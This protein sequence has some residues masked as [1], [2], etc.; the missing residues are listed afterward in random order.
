M[1]ALEVISRLRELGV[2]ISVDADELVVDAPQGAI[3][4]ELAAQI[5][6]RKVQLIAMLK[7]SARSQRFSDLPLVAAGREQELPLSYAQ[8][9]LWFLDQLEPGSS[10]YNISWTVRLKGELDVPALQHALNAVV[11]R[12]EVL[13]SCFPTIAGQAKLQLRDDVLVP[14]EQSDLN[15]ATDERL[16]AHLSR[17]AA[18][19]FELAKAPLLRVFLVRRTAT[20][21][22]LLVLIHHV[23]S[24]GASMRILFREL[25]QLYDAAVAGNLAAGLSSL[26]PLTIQYPDFALWQREWLSGEQLQQQLD[27]W[28]TKLADAPPVLAL[29]TD[30]P[31]SAALRFRGASV[32]RLLPKELAEDLRALGRTNGATLFMVMFAVFDIVLQR[33]SAQN[34]LVVG[35]PISG[36]SRTSLEG[37]IGF[38]VNT[39]VLRTQLSD[40]M[41]FRDLLRQVR[42][43]ALEAHTHQELPFEKLV[44]VLQPE[45][46]LS[47][48]PIFQVMFDLQE[49]PRWQLPVQNIE[50]IPEVIFSSR[51]STFDL[52]LSVREASNGLDAMFEYDTDLFDESTIEQFAKH[53]EALLHSALAAPDLAISSLP[54]LSES[55]RQHLLFSWG[56]ASVAG[57]AAPSGLTLHGQFAQVLARS[58]DAIAL[59]DA[60]GSEYSYAE[61]NRMADSIAM[62][63]RAQGVEPGSVVGLCA[64]RSAATIAAILGVLKSGAAWLPLDPEYPVERLCVM[65][66]VAAPDVVLVQPEFA[67][68][69]PVDQKQLL[70]DADLIS[71]TN[72]FSG[73]DVRTDAAAC[74]L[75]T[76]GSTG[77]PKGVVLGHGGLA[78]YVSQ[79]ASE[80]KV[81]PAD[82]VLQFA[83]LN[84]DISL[85]EIFVALTSGATLV[86]R[87]AGP[88]PSIQEFLSFCKLH[89]I[90]WLSLPTAY[91][92]EWAAQV[93]QD[94]LLPAE[95]KT[96]IIGGEKAQLENWR[97]WQR[98]YGSAVQLLNTY[99]PTEASIAA[100]WFDLTYQSPDAWFSLPIGRPLPGVQVYILDIQLQPQ[101]PGVPGD[102]YIGGNGVAQGYLMAEGALPQADAFLD[103]PYADGRMYRTGDRARY[104][105][106]G[107]IEY[108]GRADQQLKLRGHRVEP[109]ETAAVILQNDLVENCVVLARPVSDADDS[110]L[111]LVAWYVAAE[112]LDEVALKQFLQSRLP[113]YMVPDFYVSLESLPL[114][115]NGK[116]DVERLPSPDMQAALVAAYREPVNDRQRCIASIWQAVLG[117]SQVGLDDDFFALGGHSLLATRVVARIRDELDTD[118]PLR[119]LFNNPTV[120][121]LAAA[122]EGGAQTSRVQ[123]IRHRS[124]ADLAPL[125]FAQQRLWFLDQLQPGNAT[126]N[127]P[128]MAR[129]KGELNIPALQAAL[130][131]LTQRHESL[132]TRFAASDGEPVQI[133]APAFELPLTMHDCLAADDAILQLKLHELSQR[134]FDLQQGPLVFA[135]LLQ[136]S[137]QDHVLLLVMHHIVSDGWSMGVIYR[138][139]SVLYNVYRKDLAVESSL[140]DLPVQYADYAVWQ[141]DWLA[142]DDYPQQLSYWRQQLQGMP[143]LL[144]LHA[145]RERPSV[146]SYSGGWVD[147]ALP[148]TVS[149]ALNKL[150]AAEGSSLFMLLLA[151]FNVLL[152]RYA[153]TEDVVVGT[154]VAGRQYTELEGQ[155]GFFLNTLVLRSDLSGN[156]RFSELLQAVR[157]TALEA[158]D[159]Q[160]LPFEKL[161]EELQPERNPAYPPLAQVMFNL[162]NEPHSRVVLDGIEAEPFSLAS[163]TAKFDLNVAV[164]ERDSGLLI[165]I[166]YNSD[167]FEATTIERMLGGFQALLETVVADPAR[168]LAELPL[169]GGVQQLATVTELPA[170]ALSLSA[171]LRTVIA[172]QGDALAVDDGMQ[173]ISFARL[174]EYA[175]GLKESLSACSANSSKPIA[176]ML[177]HDAET[178]AAIAAAT[179]LDRTWVALDPNLPPTRLQ[180]IYRSAGAT[181][182]VAAAPYTEL[183]GQHFGAEAV[184]TL[185]STASVELPVA[186][187]DSESTEEL[188]YILYT[189]GTTGNPKGVPQTRRNVQAH[190]DCYAD[191]ISLSAKDRLSLFSGYGF[192]AAIMDIYSGLLHGA[193]ICPV[194]LRTTETPLHSMLNLRASVLHATPTVFRLLLR[195]QGPLETLRAVVLGGEEAT[196]A[197]F[198]DF[199][200]RFAADAL[201]INGL[202]PSESTTALQYRATYDSEML[203]SRLP[204]GLPVQGTSIELRGT[205]NKPSAFCGE[206][207]IRSDRLAPGYWQNSEAEQ[208]AFIDRSTYRSGDAARYLPDG[209]LVFAGRRDGQ[210]KLRGQRIETAGIE[211]LLEQIEGVDRAVVR[212]LQND[213]SLP[214]LCAWYQSPEAGVVGSQQL[215]TAL[216]EF[217]PESMV[218]TAFVPVSSL[219]MTSNGKLDIA[220]LPL[221]DNAPGAAYRR[222]V[223]D[224]ELQIAAVWQE[225]LDVAAVGLDDDFFA[226][227]GHSLIATRMVARVRDRLHVRVPLGELFAHPVLESFAAAVANLDADKSLPLLPQSREDRLLAP[228]SWS[229]QRLWFLDQL[230]PEST[231]YTLHR[232]TRIKGEL[233]LSRLQSA[234]DTLVSRHESLRTVFASRSGEPVQMVMPQ[235]RL[236]LNTETLSGATDSALQ[237]R[238]LDEV[239]QPFDLQQGPLLRA[240][241]ISPAVNDAVLLL[242]MHHIISDGW[243]MGVLCDELSRLYTSGPETLPDLPVQY[244]DFAIWQRDW[245]AGA[246][247]EKQLGYWRAQLADVPPVLAL[248]YDRVRPAVPSYRGAWQQKRLSIELSQSLNDLARQ[249]NCTLYMVLLAGFNILL[250]RYSGREDVVVGS[251]V[252][253]RQRSEL[254]SLIGFFLNTLVLRNDLSGN[255]DIKEVLARTRETALGAYEHQDLP[256]EKLL[257]ELQPARSMSTAPLV[258]VMFNLHNEFDRSLELGDESYVFH[259]DRGSAKFDLN[260]AVAEGKQG[261][262]LAMEYSTDLFDEASVA[263]MLDNYE[264]L[265]TAIASDPDLRL[266]ELPFLVDNAADRLIE[267]PSALPAAQSVVELF[268]RQLADYADKTAVHAGDCVWTYAELAARANRVAHDILVVSTGEPDARVGLLL[269]H[270]APMLA[271]LL[272]TL[273]AGKTYVPLDPEAPTERLQNIIQSAGVSLIVCGESYRELADSL[274]ANLLHVVSVAVGSKPDP[275]APD[276][277]PAADSLAYILFTSGTTGKPK[278]V[279]QTHR[280]LLH[281]AMTYRDALAIGSE[282]RL[283]LLSPF[284]FDAAVMDIY[285]SLISGACLCPL[286]IKNEAYLGAVIEEIAASSITLLHATPTV[287]RYLMRHKICRHDVTQVRAV[288]LGGEEAK[289]GDF[290]FYKKNF[291]SKAVF[292]NGLGPSEC[293]LALQWFADQSTELMGGLIPAGLPVAAT[294]VMLLDANLEES[295]VS[296]ELLIASEYV[297]PGYWQQDELTERAFIEMN[298]RRWYRTGD[299]ARY[300]PDGNLVFAGRV[301]EQIKLRGHRIEPGEIEARLMSHEHVDRAVVA[302]RDD[303]QGNARLVAWVV[304]KKRQSVE[305]TGLRD[306]LKGRLPRYMMPSVISVQE[307]L[308]LTPNGKVDRRALPAPKW[309]RNED[310]LYI[311]PRNDTEE[312]LAAIW[313]DVLG[314]GRVGVDDDFFDLGGH[315]LLAM[316]LMARTTE[317]L[318]VGLPLRRLFDGP[319][320]AEVA[321]AID[322]VRWTLASGES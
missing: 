264:L 87:D 59:C 256:F 106:D 5:R 2:K 22:V 97:R 268:D 57:I 181:V 187:A 70:L 204:V 31:R 66:G 287:Y 63:L 46:E 7:W 202:G 260:M 284:G 261:L 161:V 291:D 277:E 303:L 89:R 83:S 79:L 30:R 216:R 227:G 173:Q 275:G 233:D 321:Q 208:A 226:L 55:E 56:T 290:E 240:T 162:H 258:Q 139:L 108:L 274:S 3:T 165:G 60:Q 266:T 155:V 65:L 169:P 141:R 186:A 109:A 178:V 142:S 16:R 305:A 147:L 217:L 203:H 292:V 193:C 223:T 190:I 117:V 269:G 253:G 114:T 158:Y 221:P 304:A 215:R 23:V 94:L 206:L 13:R 52:T 296:G 235:M 88:A 289:A 285:A 32:I 255:P 116:I 72:E 71:G 123:V 205:D 15:G 64:Q 214:Q 113:D 133:I 219:P 188:A 35:T 174:S 28:T 281:H 49:E 77:T 98:S 132:R 213:E 42:D 58:P 127:L 27:Y 262:L 322:D 160:D 154:P 166:E 40:D 53:Y 143:A 36:R 307:N 175:A 224:T 225:V 168:R 250:A 105:S 189:S 107:N 34:D 38:F 265:L 121:S 130:N 90:N 41:S 245:L 100:T 171:R 110:L 152:A 146:Q 91:W 242:S 212:V 124:S 12:H 199:R 239:R 82:R 39:A 222:P 48:T 135:E 194:N 26:P 95:L 251:P 21:H 234:L 310:Q 167:I 137:P 195:E 313:G 67:R 37:L 50:V 122:M 96:V 153:G 184:I 295:A 54:M 62:A 150:A 138:E 73:S 76:S 74:I 308:P 254:E 136:V 159:N 191:S 44:E 156:P 243:S 210:I 309:G 302:L 144:D 86:L 267:P 80:T 278:G 179:L 244:I 75:F 43:T 19:P 25:A 200:H 126:F 9:R 18:Q 297:T 176:L 236:Q 68:I 172:E 247:L 198:A 125:S 115:V 211:R 259:I 45:R 164:H 170:A 282:D 14:L 237:A 197:D 85:E 246:E 120:A 220:A 279:M 180:D 276:I 286:D 238:L 218:P 320:I 207:I 209:N 228:L 272:G 157:H 145:D 69:L 257:E 149:D 312:K 230:E 4:A 252:A 1:T 288:V 294:Q 151:A 271:A 231:A 248:P 301:D 84:F 92:H 29:P 134:C 47:H 280:N 185:Q 128:W 306:Y 317:S 129:L 102:L 104:L 182:V 314:L 119:L 17:L 6:E 249:E 81:A 148:A 241:L 10:A 78:N 229:Q 263:T 283:S 315:S 273:K 101:P 300:L 163:G 93:N 293:T 177:G 131:T 298:D 61:L 24:D 118:I 316:Q 33:Y 201:L 99:G 51:T 111:L 103:N 140:P 299:R 232:A 112:G 196:A 270:D 20:E 311:A 11:Q 8:Q 319:T 183:A 318:Q 192:D